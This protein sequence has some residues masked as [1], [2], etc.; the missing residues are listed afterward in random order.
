MPVQL[1]EMH[2]KYI[3]YIA[4]S[5]KK[6]EVLYKHAQQYPFS[7]VLTPDSCR[8]ITEVV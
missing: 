6:T 7:S 8:T 1:G 2:N 5:T 3:L 4:R